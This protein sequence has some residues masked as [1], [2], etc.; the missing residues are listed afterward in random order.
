MR[1]PNILA[2]LAAALPLVLS[3]SVPPPEMLCNLGSQR[4]HDNSVEECAGHGNY[5]LVQACTKGEYCAIDTAH[6]NALGECIPLSLDLSSRVP[7]PEMMC[8][9]GTQRCYNNKFEECGGHGNYFLVQACAANE[10]CTIDAAHPNALGQ[11]IPQDCIQPPCT[12]K[13]KRWRGTPDALEQYPKVGEQRCKEKQI[14]ECG[15]ERSWINTKRCN[16]SEKCVEKDGH[17]HCATI[18]TPNVP[19]G[20][21]PKVGLQRCVGSQIQECGIERS[22]INTQLCDLAPKCV[23]QDGHAHCE[24][25]STPARPAPT[26]S[27]P[28]PCTPGDRM[29][30]KDA[31]TLYLCGEDN[32]FH[33]EKKCLTPGDCK[34]DGPGQAHCERGGTAPPNI[35]SL[36]NGT[37]CTRGDYACDRNRRFM[38]ECN[39]QGKWI[40]PYQ[41]SRAGACQPINSTVEYPAG[42]LYCEGFPKFLYPE[43]DNRICETISSCE[44]MRYKYCMGVSDPTL[45]RP[46]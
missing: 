43:G 31:Y 44:F 6:P 33:T 25:F 20:P 37:E 29:C 9:L 38:F 30:S 27:V 35:R 26:T 12:E 42:R 11:C 41:C 16:A 18:S 2:V 40:K 7:P 23:E 24:I 45:K 17:A 8:K 15:I 1:V 46:R 22:W 10:Y 3:A 14:Q 21:C 32:I 28:E 34:T 4:C 5:L 13:V 36:T 39:N 19:G